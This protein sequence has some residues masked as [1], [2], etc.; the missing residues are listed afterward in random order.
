[1]APKRKTKLKF[2]LKLP[3]EFMVGLYITLMILLTLVIYLNRNNLEQTYFRNT[4][5]IYYLGFMLNL[6]NMVIFTIYYN[7]V[8]VSIHSF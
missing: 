4:Y 2:T 3:Y 7:G 5:F 1:M 6:L 8:V